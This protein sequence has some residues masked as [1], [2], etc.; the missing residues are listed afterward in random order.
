MEGNIHRAKREQSLRVGEH[1]QLLS[2]ENTPLPPPP[3]T[4]EQ[5]RSNPSLSVPVL[6]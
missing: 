1:S 6:A 4:E 2:D 3:P 5:P